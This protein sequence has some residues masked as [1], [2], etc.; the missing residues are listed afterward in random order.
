MW[1][2]SAVLAGRRKRK[3]RRSIALVLDQEVVAT[4]QD[5]GVE[6]EEDPEAGQQTES[7]KNPAERSHPNSGMFLPLVLST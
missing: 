3:R 6:N 7:L 4:D 5:Q 1:L 2:K